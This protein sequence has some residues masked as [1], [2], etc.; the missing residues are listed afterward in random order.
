MS[1]E[2]DITAENI[3]NQLKKPGR[4]VVKI[5]SALLTNDGLG[6]D[7]DAIA[8]WVE[9]LAALKQRGYDIVLV[10]SGSVAEGLVRLGWSK[11]P[12]ELSKLQAAAAVGQMG[13]V[14]TYEQEFQKFDLNTAQILL[15]HDD[16]SNRTRYL[17][18]RS[19][20]KTLMEVGAIPVINENDTVVTDEIRFGDNDTLA[21][22]VANLIQADTLVILTD[23][24]GLYAEDPRKNPNAEFVSAAN[25]DDPAIQSMASSS[26][27]GLGRGGMQTKLNAARLATR[28]GTNT[29]ICSGRKEEVLLRLAKGE[30]I[31][32]LLYAE[33]APFNARKQ[34]LAGQLRVCGELSLDEGASKVL[35]QAGRSL[36]PVGVTRVNGR[37]KRGELVSILDQ[38]GTEIGRGLVNYSSVDALKIIG[39][40]SEQILEI[41]GFS[42]GD[43]LIHRDNLILV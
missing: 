10:S 9:Q 24:Q 35:K 27:G 23:Q 8:H 7:T 16:L 32:T 33:T 15:T 31:G 29:L 26:G 39:Q 13:L 43:E 3:R 40:S 34:W 20:I 17:N 1:T 6:L 21:G 2:A 4:W 12:T 18:A 42:D 37:F 22:L 38:A 30:N 14:Q 36:L 28:S 25:A 5:G 11:R 19:T 41:L